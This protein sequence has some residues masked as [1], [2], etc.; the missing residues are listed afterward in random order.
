MSDRRD[1]SFNIGDRPMITDR[2]TDGG[3]PDP[4]AAWSYSQGGQRSARS[5]ALW[6]SVATVIL[7]A[8]ANY[9]AAGGVRLPFLGPTVGFWFVLIHPTYLLCTTS[10]WGRT[11]V[12]ERIGYSLGAVLL[13]LL[14]AGLVVNFALPVVGSQ[15]PLDRIP[16]V[17]LGDIITLSLYLLRRRRPA[18]IRW[19]AN[20]KT[21]NWREHRLLVG[22]TASVALAVLGAN[23]LNNGAGDRVSL[24]A[25]ACMVVT[26]SLLL[27]WHRPVRDGIA[28]ATIYLVSLAL[29]LMTSLRGWYVTGHDIQLEYRVFQLTAA[30][31]HWSGSAL[32][33]AYNA[34]LSITILPTEFARVLNVD[35]PYIYKVFFQIIFAF[36][37]V[38]V[39]ALSRRYW[40]RPVAMLAA[41]YFAGF[42]T[43]FT[44]MP[45][46]NRQE[47]AFLFVCIGMLAITNFW[48]AQNQRRLVLIAAGLGVE[49][50]H[51]STMYLFV[52][53]LLLAWLIDRL[54][55]AAPRMRRKGLRPT[56]GHGRS[57]QWGL[58]G[59]NIGLGSIAALASFT[60]LWGGLATQTAGSALGTVGSAVAGVFEHSGAATPYSL[61]SR[62]TI[63]A[64][65]LLQN[66]R[67]ATLRINAS[68]RAYVPIAS[69]SQV[70]TPLVTEPSL[71]LTT[72][73]R[74]LSDAGVPAPALNGTIRQSAAKDEQLFVVVG[75][76]VLLTVRRFT[77]QL[78]RELA[79][80]AC[81]SVVIVGLFAIFPDLSVDYGTLRAFQEALILLAPV[82]VAGSLAVFSFFGQAWS[83]RAAM[84][85]C[86]AVF[87]STTGLIPQI[88]GGY[89]AQLSLN[90]SG[91]YYDVY[92]QHP[93][94]A[95]AVSWL[96]SQHGVGHAG[97]DAPLG[98]TTANRFSFT[99]PSD[100]SSRQELADFYPTLIGRESWVVLGYTTVR[101]G[102]A[103]LYIDGQL[104][105]YRYPTGFLRNNK[106][107]V[108]SNGASEIYK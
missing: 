58:T 46:L 57:G 15:R 32:K 66:Y 1:K 87:S 71:P 69:P 90:N 76:T 60:F 94:E 53:T 23:R 30:N 21:L 33:G 43:F 22:A 82:L 59:R 31:G 44:D 35:D 96:A 101:T 73:G 45:F 74:V 40:S 6:A 3:V 104:I 88:L 89:Q 41:I 29:L 84:M 47:I 80:L 8:T 38:L 55:E 64:P 72:T 68:S 108:Y 61:F 106:N 5:S 93:Q 86:V 11:S 79:A 49:L 95:A 14:T 100:V 67:A 7:V 19:R 2:T 28:S 62:S 34:C 27:R 24:L 20:L 83:L 98:A 50:S 103:V 105:Y 77:R 85:I 4:T 63:N 54:I 91:Q 37:P 25:L 42:P 13:L 52:G 97:L 92:Y 26:I 9:I 39:Y 81:G 17:I 56:T 10:L 75:L 107:L 48:W 16:I 99:S 51:Y 18:Q 12:A 36:C 78:S 65:V 102:R 70:P